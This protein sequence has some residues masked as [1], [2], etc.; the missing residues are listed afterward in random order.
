MLLRE[1]PHAG[2]STP[3]LILRLIEEGRGAD[4]HGYRAELEELVRAA[5]AD[6]PERMAGR[7]A[8]RVE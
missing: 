6:L 5:A 1:S 4:P 2:A 3:E 7:R 8:A